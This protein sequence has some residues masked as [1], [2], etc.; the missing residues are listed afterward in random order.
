MGLDTNSMIVIRFIIL[1]A[2]IANV[3]KHFFS[4]KRFTVSVFVNIFMRISRL[5]GKISRNSKMALH[6]TSSVKNEA[7]YD[8]DVIFKMFLWSC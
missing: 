3:F 4:I 1:L 5:S 8:R 7:K 6:I 2:K